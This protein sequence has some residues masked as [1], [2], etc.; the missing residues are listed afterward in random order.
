M[1][2]RYGLTEVTCERVIFEGTSSPSFSDYR[3]WVRV[4]QVVRDVLIP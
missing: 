4:L 2:G 1:S 3:S